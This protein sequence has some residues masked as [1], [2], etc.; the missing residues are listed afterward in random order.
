MIFVIWNFYFS[1][2]PKQFAV[3]TGNPATGGTD[4]A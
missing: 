3:F 1:S 2:T 4:L